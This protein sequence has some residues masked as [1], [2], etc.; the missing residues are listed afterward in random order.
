MRWLPD[1]EICRLPSVQLAG[2]IVD[3]TRYSPFHSAFRPLMTTEVLDFYHAAE[4]LSAAM[5]AA[6]GEGSVDARQ[7]FDLKRYALRHQKD[8]V[9]VIIRALAALA[10]KHPNKERVAKVLAYFRSNRKRMRYADVAAQN[11]P[12]GS[13]VVEAACK[14]L[15]GQRLKLSGMRWGI[16]G[17]QAI[18]NFRGWHQSDRFDAAWALIAAQYKAEVTTIA[19]VVNLSEARKKARQ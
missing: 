4:H 1:F 14:T 19:N 18:L 9:D 15:V 2:H 10:K 8:G 3:L 12:I 16:E 7:H 11:L 6:F 13:G 5:N 17:G